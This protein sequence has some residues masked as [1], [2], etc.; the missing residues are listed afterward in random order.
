MKIPQ[1]DMT[2]TCVD[3]WHQDLWYL[4]NATYNSQNKSLTSRWTQMDELMYM[5][6]E[7]SV[8]E[9]EL[10]PKNVEFWKKQVCA[11]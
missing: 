3:D 10:K 11:K 7:K 4:T 9:G 6:F 8:Y 2:W 1:N 5:G